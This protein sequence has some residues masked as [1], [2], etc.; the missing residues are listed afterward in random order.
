MAQ[1]NYTPIS[2]YYSAT[3]SATPTAGN[4]VAG[5]LALNTNDGKLYYKDSSGVVQTLASKAGN[6]NVSSF[7]AGS[8]GLTPST[9]TTGVVTL[10]GTLNVANG[11]TGVTTSTGSGKTVLSASPTFTGT[12]ACASLSLSSLTSV[13]LTYATT[14]GLLTD[15]ANLNFD[16]SNLLVGSTSSTFTSAGR[17]VINA[18]GSAQAL[19]GLSVGGTGVGYLYH[20]GTDITLMNNVS[21]GVAIFGTN[22]TERM[23]ITS[24]GSVLI[25]ATSSPF[26]KLYVSDGTVG[27]GLGPYSTGSVAYAGTWTNHSLAFVTNGAEAGRFD[28]AGNL[29]LGVTP[30]AWAS[31]SKAIEL[32]AV[33]PCYL[34]FNSS[35]NPYGYIYSNAYFNGTNNIYKNSSYASVYA[36]N[37]AGQH[38]WFTAPSGTA[39]NAITFTQAMTLDNS[40]NLLVGTSTTNASTHHV[41]Q[42]SDSA[43]F[44]A[45]VVNSSAATSAL[46][47]YIQYPNF[48]PNNTSSEF[49]YCVDSSLLRM[50]IRSNGGIANYSANNVNL[51]DERT[52][53]DIQNAGSYLDKI[54]AIPVRTFKYKDQTDNELNLGVIAQEVE[55]VAPELVD[56]SGFG[57]TPEDGIPLKAIYQTDLQYAL[58]KCIQE[59]Q[60]LIESLTQRIAI[61]E[62]K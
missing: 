10:A 27:V 45:G 22:N 17:T 6:V 56:N 34:A 30:S 59:Q 12:V 20:N 43:K 50:S 49:L 8:T 47:L 29:G 1:T 46:G 11:G 5:E 18:N 14:G 7:S 32:S 4:L 48:A 44:V 35:T 60:A 2:L 58:M 51:S 13:R 36:I 55:K 61:L 37:S 41:L 40:G 33:S 9:A 16:G 15:S 26:P 62:N 3:A 24:A 57:E 23:R 28:T 52:K 25:G 39:G 21:T 53:K 38:Q 42:Y 54:C 31:T 19:L